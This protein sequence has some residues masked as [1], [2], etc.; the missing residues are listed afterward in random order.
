MAV[1]QIVQTFALASNVA[2]NGTVVVGYPAVPFN[3][4]QNYYQ[5]N[6]PNANLGSGNFQIS[7]RKHTLKIG[8]NIYNY[9]KDFTLSF[10]NVSAGITITNKTASAWPAGSQAALGLDLN[11]SLV[12]STAPVS[13]TRVVPLR[14]VFL[15]LGSPVVAAVAG[16]A[17]VQLVGAAGN[18][19]LNGPTVSGGVA[20]LDVPRNFTLT[21]ATTDHSAR[22][23]TVYGKDEYGASMVETLAGPNNNTV[24][25]KKAFASIS[26]VAV[27][28]AIATNGVS[29]GY[30]TA[31][32]LPLAVR[33]AGQITKEL[34]DGAAAT[35]GT[36]AYALDNAASTATTADVRGTYIPNSASDGAKGLLIG[37]LISDGSDIGVAQYT[38]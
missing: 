33:K 3:A 5:N 27:D 2:A 15:D 25:G 37:V 20:Y 30:G 23:F 29:V 38:V 4:S 26:R 28:G 8:N 12:N 14:E 24:S 36:F 9:P 7:D 6:A 32:G 17:A 34:Q 10:G 11:G 19:T 18:L 13:S 35:A 16:V 21:V 22:T 1:N 31:L